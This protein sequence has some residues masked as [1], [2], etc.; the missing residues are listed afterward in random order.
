MCGDGVQGFECQIQRLGHCAGVTGEPGEGCEQGRGRGSSGTCEGLLAAVSGWQVT[1]GSSQARAGRCGDG[2][3]RAWLTLRSKE[4]G[5]GQQAWRVGSPFTVA[6][7]RSPAP[8]QGPI[9]LP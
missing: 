1:S 9:L 5:D 3:L 4:T 6:V 7:L 8:F 2:M